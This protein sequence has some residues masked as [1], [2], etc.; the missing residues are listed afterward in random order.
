ML[1]L[2]WP[3]C[4]VQTLTLDDWLKFGAVA[5]TGVLLRELRMLLDACL[6]QKLND[7]MTELGTQPIIALVSELLSV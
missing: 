4:P 6:L 5:K 3:I 7:P 2:L 1:R